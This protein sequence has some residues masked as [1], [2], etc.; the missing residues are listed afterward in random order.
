MRLIASIVFGVFAVL[1]GIAGILA[2]ISIWL[3]LT[4]R[5]G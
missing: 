2:F 1:Y 3:L 5:N 4:R